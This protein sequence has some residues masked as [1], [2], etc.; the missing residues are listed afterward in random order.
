M[1]K[2]AVSMP[3]GNGGISEWPLT[4]GL[5]GTGS[6]SARPG[7]A[8]VG[9]TMRTCLPSPSIGSS[10]SECTGVEMGRAAPGAKA[11]PL[12]W[13]GWGG[14][15]GSFRPDALEDQRGVLAGVDAQ[16]I[17]LVTAVDD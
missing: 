17:D 13:P 8:S 14:R 16:G 15:D 10:W 7:S 3:S 9:V 4:R 5:A 2:T 12:T 1:P 11:T 6:G